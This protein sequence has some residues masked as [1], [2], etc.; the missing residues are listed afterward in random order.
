MTRYNTVVQ[1]SK[2]FKAEGNQFDKSIFYS[3]CKKLKYQIFM[4]E[5]IILTAGQEE[6][7]VYLVLDGQVE[8]QDLSLQPMPI[9]E[10][11]HYFGGIVP[12][13]PQLYSIKS[14]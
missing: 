3:F 10:T 4:P 12:N 14:L 5:D 11:G 13:I 8:I 1:E 9:L 2:L 7:T 6:N